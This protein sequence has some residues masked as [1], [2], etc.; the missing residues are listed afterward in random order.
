MAV[1]GRGRNR[2][3]TGVKDLQCR[4]VAGPGMLPLVVVQV[5]TVNKLIIDVA[6]SVSLKIHMELICKSIFPNQ[7]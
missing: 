1:T 3:E 4:R 7:I 2:A 6:T 5:T